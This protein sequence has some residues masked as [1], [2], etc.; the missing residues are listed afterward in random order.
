M[1]DAAMVT[2]RRQVLEVE[3]QGSEEDGFAIQRRLTGVCADVLAPAI[4]TALDPIDPG[5]GYICLDRLTIDVTLNSITGLERELA[6][7][8]Q[9]GLAEHFRQHPL[10][11][12]ESTVQ[13]PAPGGRPASGK[14]LAPGG[15]QGPTGPGGPR[16]SGGLGGSSRLDRSGD[17]Y[18]R[19]FAQTVDAALDTFLRTGRLPWSFRLPPGR[20]LEDV[21]QD[22][23]HDAWG[24]R[25]PPPTIRDRLR[26]VL[27][28]PQARERLAVQFTPRFV[29]A[30]LCCLSPVAATAAAQ[31][32]V[33]L[34]DVGPASPAGRSFIRQ[35]RVTAI[36]AAVAGHRP[37]ASELV[38]LAWT[39]RSPTGRADH[40]LAAALEREWP[41]STGSVPVPV[42]AVQPA[43]SQPP[44]RLDIDDRGG[45][46]VDCAGIV[47][48]HPFLPRFF[49]GLGIAAKSEL[50][51]PGRAVCLLH[52]L[53]T[54][55]LIAPEHRVTLGKVLCELPP[56]QP[57][58]ADVGLADAETAE[59]TALVEAVI[60]HWEALRGTTPGGLR[61]EFLQRP[62]V[63][64][65]TSGGGWL[66]R[67][68][69]RTADILLDQLPWGFSPVWLPWMS[70]LMMVEWR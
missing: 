18:H 15:H 46:L 19:T 62:G 39:A 44:A 61:V 9:R 67:V 55:E 56:G 35:V 22:A 38:R 70:H 60:G 26:R 43:P 27:A 8:V 32:E 4:E 17:A 59:A 65:A 29:A 66:L 33:T 57:V 24:H 68:E 45:L 41:A 20:S 63:L 12:P 11:R 47:L 50:I 69:T 30:V 34:N 40:I 53:A 21:V 64:S 10:N 49:E 6:G 54:G 2:I 16:T 37:V 58:E 36:E 48:L 25:D 14:P 23:W 1:G 51:D 7:A 13:G 31:V 5:D 52:H 42:Q 3:L 28:L